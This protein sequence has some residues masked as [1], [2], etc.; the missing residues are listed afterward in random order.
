MAH[1]PWTTLGIEPTTDSRAIRRAYAQR[2]KVTQPEDDAAGFQALRN[3]YELALQIAASE[4][5]PPAAPVAFSAPA[6]ADLD[7]D[8]TTRAS[9][10]APPA[11]GQPPDPAAEWLEG[12]LRVL[13]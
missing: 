10:P 6:V 5:A 8:F 9:V 13:A 11:P 3:A 7:P 4:F 12:R 1:F 2:L